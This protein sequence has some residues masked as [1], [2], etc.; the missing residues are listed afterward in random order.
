MTDRVLVTHAGPIA[1]TIDQLSNA[2]ETLADTLMMES[3]AQKPVL[4]SKT[5]M[6][7]AMVNFEN[8]PPEFKD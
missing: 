5:R 2:R 4:G 8:R 6:E 1:D 7:V 3:T